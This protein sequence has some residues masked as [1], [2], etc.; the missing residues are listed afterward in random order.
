MKRVLLLVLLTLIIAPSFTVAAEEDGLLERVQYYGIEA[1]INKDFS[2]SHHVT[3]IFEGLVSNLEY[4]FPSEIYGLEV[5]NNYGHASCTSD[6]TVMGTNIK[7]KVTTDPE[8]ANK[9]QIEMDFNTTDSIKKLF[10]N[11]RFEESYGISLPIDSMTALIH[12][13]PT[14]VLASSNPSESYYPENGKTLSDGRH[15]LLYWERENVTSSE[16]LKY[17]VMYIL[18][19]EPADTSNFI[20]TLLAVIALIVIM[21]VGIYMKRGSSETRIEN[22]MPL[23]NQDEKKVIDIL[24]NHDSEVM[25]KMIVIESD[26]SKAKVSRLI[27]NLS[28]RNIIEIVSFGK[29]NRIKLKVNLG[30]PK[31]TKPDSG[32]S[33]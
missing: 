26:F 11:Y 14:G 6:F 2:V 22:V 5:K 16:E 27:K 15:I 17:A 18:P 10:G 23:L 31:K 9:T 3:L 32:Y 29:K 24:R 7:C 12:M 4:N 19:G 28:E 13:P 1:T 20:I 8:Q 21:G 30:K 25:Q 33:I